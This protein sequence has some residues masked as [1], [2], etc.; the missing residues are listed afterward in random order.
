MPVCTAATS[1]SV[2][3]LAGLP[4][5]RATD[6]GTSACV[7]AAARPTAP[8]VAAAGRARV[9]RPAAAPARP[10]VAGGAQ[11]LHQLAVDGG[12]AGEA[13]RDLLQLL[14]VFHRLAPF[15]PSLHCASG[16]SGGGS[17]TGAGVVSR[18]WSSLTKS[19]AEAVMMLASSARFRL[20]VSLRSVLRI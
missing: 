15:C 18:C 10:P 8:P 3:S 2:A 20:R 6:A 19:G 9:A 14:R 1:T 11:P 16:C 5:A 13:L 4:S 12:Q 17:G 7:G